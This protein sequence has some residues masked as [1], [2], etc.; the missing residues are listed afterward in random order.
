MIN[1]YHRPETIGAAID[2][3]AR[4]EPVTIPLG[5]GTKISQRTKQEFA[6]V[7]LQGLGLNHIKLLENQ[8]EIDSSVN[9]EQL[10]NYPDLVPGLKNVITHQAGQNLRQMATMGGAVAALDGKSPILTALLALDTQ[11]IWE[12]GEIITSIGDWLPVRH[13]Q[14]PGLLIVKLR[15]PRQVDFR[16]EA[17]ARTPMDFPLVCV[18]AVIWPSGRTRVTLGG[19]GAEPIL[20]FDGVGKEG[21]EIVAGSAFSK[22]GDEW[23]SSEYRSEI[24]Q[25][26]TKRILSFDSTDPS[27]S[28]GVKDGAG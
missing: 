4:K 24:A 21:A 3:L 27:R 23:A 2:L 11:L 15:I 18:A 9:L 8:L 5:G 17:V 6:V 10:C 13:K 7:D 26:L 16:Y 28:W 1:E 12:P 20:V 25:V 14:K 22:A 19:F